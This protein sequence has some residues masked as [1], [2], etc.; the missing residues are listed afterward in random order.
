[1]CVS[2]ETV[3]PWLGAIFI[4]ISFGLLIGWGVTVQWIVG[5]VFS[6][7]YSCVLFIISFQLSK[8][9]KEN[10][11]SPEIAGE[12]DEESRM[13]QTN[14]T[15]S[16]NQGLRTLVTLLFTLAVISVGVTGLIIPLNLIYCNYGDGYGYYNNNYSWDTD[17]SLFSNDVQNWY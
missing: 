8:R 16:T 6:V 4:N 3:F 15:N 14:S 7:V 12:H 2:T 11:T 10:T 13:T 17:T 1:M 9:V 5:F